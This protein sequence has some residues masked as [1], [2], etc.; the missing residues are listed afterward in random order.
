M[1]RSASAL[2]QT[3]ER[4]VQLVE[5][6]KHTLAVNLRER[7]VNLPDP[8]NPWE[9]RAVNHCEPN[10]EFFDFYYIRFRE[11]RGIKSRSKLKRR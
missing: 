2:E 8:A 4:L 3:K 6:V 10:E 9:R 7:P 1:R 11:K 5:A